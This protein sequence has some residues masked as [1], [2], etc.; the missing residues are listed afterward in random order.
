MN[1]VFVQIV[2][3]NSINYIG[4][5]LDALA[6]QTFTDFSLLVIDNRSN[7]QTVKFV[8]DSYPTAAVLE[9]LKN[10]GY[11]KA[12]NQGLRLAKS[13]YVL[14]MNPDVVLEPDFLETLIKFADEHPEAGSFCGK[15][16]RL[17]SQMLDDHND[18]SGLRESIQ[19]DIID[20]T[21]L[22]I[23]KSRKEENRGEGQTDTGQFERAEEVFGASGACVLYRLEAIQDV[24]IKNEAFDQ[25]FFAYKEDVDLAW[26]L[27]LY[28]WQSWYNPASIA[29]HHRGLASA[30]KEMKKVIKHRKK[31]SKF[32]RAL[33]FRNHK[34]TLIK[35]DQWINVFLALPWVLGREIASLGYVL[36]FEPFLFK[37]LGEFFKLLPKALL[38]RKII[39]A[40][41]K[42]TPA[43]IR[44]WF[45]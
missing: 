7:D 40:H 22:I 35:N 30:G 28:G 8:R 42:V 33:S 15:T 27:R 2:T 5:C 6:E 25:D 18:E 10:T 21:G 45:R 16:F 31:V 32:L 11:A 39:M 29:Y 13:E 38:K 41:R 36:F 23:H 24:M 12:N 9:N 26:R 34:L 3:W 44:R 19:T 37:S 14:V 1:K 4:E 43:E 17:H 20:S